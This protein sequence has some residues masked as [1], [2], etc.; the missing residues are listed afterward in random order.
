MPLSSYNDF[1]HVLNSFADFPLRFE[2]P[3]INAMY[4]DTIED[5]PAQLYLSAFVPDFEINSYN[6][7]FTLKLIIHEIS[8]GM[9]F[10][11]GN[12]SGDRIVLEPADFGDIWM[13]PQKDFS[14][15]ARFNITAI[16]STPIETKAVSRHIEINITAVADVPF[17]N[18]SVP[19]H[20]WNSSEK[21]IPVFLEAHLNDQDGSENLAIVFSGLPTGYRLVHV[22]GTSLVNRSNTR[23]PPNASR[24]FISINETL[25]PFVLRVLATAEERFNGDQANQT[26]DVNVTFCGKSCDTE[27]WLQNRQSVV[28]F[29]VISMYDCGLRTFNHS[30]IGP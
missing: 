20:H 7:N 8:E 22:N 16:V 18:V 4:S 17:L 25:K 12:R 19:C 15:L 23:A 26:A 29:T 13:I 2:P 11:K 6:K 3:I 5:V 21:L 24:L 28:L 14:G 27:I 10:S 30:G 1:N 9:A